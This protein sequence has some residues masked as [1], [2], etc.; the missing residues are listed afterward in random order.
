MLLVSHFTNSGRQAKLTDLGCVSSLLLHS[1]LSIAYFSTVVYSKHF[2]L[3]RLFFLNIVPYRLSHTDIPAFS[4]H[5]LYLF[6]TT[7][8]QT[9]FTRLM[10]RSKSHV[11]L[12]Q[13]V[14]PK[15]NSDFGIINFILSRCRIQFFYCLRRRN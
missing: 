9:L 4:T 15:Q 11:L 13:F 14:L 6:P 2:C 3:L 1:C 7:L 10:S 12:H 8:L 5:V